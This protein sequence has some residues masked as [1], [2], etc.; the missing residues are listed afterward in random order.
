MDAACPGLE[1]ALGPG[2]RA[3]SYCR[4][5]EGGV[6]RLGDEVVVEPAGC[7]GRLSAVGR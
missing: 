1:E 7:P 2:R 6:V 4:V 3:G 5:L